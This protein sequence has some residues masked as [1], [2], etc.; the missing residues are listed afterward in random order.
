MNDREAGQS[1]RSEVLCP[2][3]L[4]E[5]SGRALRYADALAAWYEARLTVLFV[6]PGLRVTSTERDVAAFVESAIGAHAA[7][8]RVTDG[9]VVSEIVRFAAALPAD[10][11]VLGTHGISGF[12]QLLLG[13]VTERVLREAPCPVLT[14]PPGVA[15]PSPDAASPATVVCAVDFSPSSARALAYA[16]SI[17]RKA[18]GRLVLLH[19]LE[20]FDDEVEAP[21]PGGSTH[22][23]PTSEEDARQGLEELLTADARAC[24]PE[25]VVGHGSPAGEVLRIVRESD[26]GLIVLGVRGRSALD[27]TLFGSTAQRVVREAPCPVLT[28]RA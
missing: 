18:R 7:D 26:A 22:G 13:S 3:D 15:R 5:I 8:L 28:V 23:F 1:P 11:V 12:K 6:R 2:L 4:S 21:G 25:L 9:D 27:R 20:W 24:D 19:A 10:F 14:V 16:V 17:A